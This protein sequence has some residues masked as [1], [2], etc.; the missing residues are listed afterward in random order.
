MPP[1]D[2][3]EVKLAEIDQAFTSRIF[4]DNVFGL[5]WKKNPLIAESHNSEL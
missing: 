2:Q 3:G 5:Q 1:F 4:S